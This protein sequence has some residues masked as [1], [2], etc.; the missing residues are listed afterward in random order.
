MYVQHVWNDKVTILLCIIITV[1]KINQ[2][3]NDNKWLLNS[4]MKYYELL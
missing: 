2:M 3:T 4:G 1:I